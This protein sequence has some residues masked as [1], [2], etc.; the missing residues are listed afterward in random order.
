M[1]IRNAFI[2]L[3]T[4][5]ALAVGCTAAQQTTA[6]TVAQSGTA[7]CEIV[8]TAADPA[9]APL[10]T[11]AEAVEEAI[12]ALVASAAANAVAD[13]GTPAARNLAT[14]V[15]VAKPTAAQIYAYLLAHGAV[16]VKK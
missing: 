4:V 16:T 13:A 1:K 14:A 3:A 6:T 2:A 7:V 5:T 11:T 12:Q 8:F 10:C 15:P 9:L